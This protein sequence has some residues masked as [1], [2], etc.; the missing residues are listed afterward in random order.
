MDPSNFLTVLY[1]HCSPII[2]LLFYTFHDCRIDICDVFLPCTFSAHRSKTNIS[3]VPRAVARGKSES[4]PANQQA[5]SGT[6]NGA[7]ASSVTRMSNDD[8]RKLLAKQ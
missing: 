8:F 1:I 6:G 7:P 5:S 2:L 3:L 4:A